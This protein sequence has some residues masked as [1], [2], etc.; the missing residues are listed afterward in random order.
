MASIIE[1]CGWTVEQLNKQTEALS[2]FLGEQHITNRQAALTLIIGLME[3]GSRSSVCLDTVERYLSVALFTIAMARRGWTGEP[4]LNTPVADAPPPTANASQ[5]V[6][7]INALGM[8][9]ED[10]AEGL[11]QC[12]HALLKEKPASRPALLKAMQDMIHEFA[13]N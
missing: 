5:I 4:T 7:T 12:A 10:A 1:D 8:T 9:A 6:Q 3:I 13:A 2:K 11:K